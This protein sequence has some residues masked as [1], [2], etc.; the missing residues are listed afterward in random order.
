M[1]TSR[2]FAIIAAP[3]ALQADVV[4]L[5]NGD[6]LT[7]KVTQIHDGKLTLETAYAGAV[8]IAQ[9]NVVSMTLD[10]PANVSGGELQGTVDAAGLRD[11][12]TLWLP[13]ADIPGAPKPPPNPWSFSL[14]IEGLYT[15]GNSRNVVGGLLSEANYIRPEDYTLKLFG[16]IRYDKSNGDVNEHKLFGGVDATRFLS[17]HNGWYGREELLT[18]RVNSIKLRSSFATGYE[19]YF[20]KNA[21]PGGLE[22]LR[23]RAGLGHRYEKHHGKDEG[24]NSN[25]TADFGARLHKRLNENLAWTTEVTHAPAIDDFA[26][27]LF[28]H[29]SRLAV[30]LVKKWRVTHELGVQHA[31]NSR[32]ADGNEKLDTTCYARLR[33][34]W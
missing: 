8:N 20:F 13:G 7:G 28:T 24:S 4:R 25:M 1:K 14:A 6:Q 18:D 29:D 32:P 21:V 11:I 3:L 33:K 5:D 22:M 19:Y 34:T 15:D 12:Q 17:E 30:D 10:A 23:F 31:Y 2:L 9:T 26:N 16:G 27:F